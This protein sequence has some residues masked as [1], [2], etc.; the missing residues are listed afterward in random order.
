M[1][2]NI[3]KYVIWGSIVQDSWLHYMFEQ[4]CFYT[5]RKTHKLMAWF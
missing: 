1:V 5:A 4:S 3:V 2:K